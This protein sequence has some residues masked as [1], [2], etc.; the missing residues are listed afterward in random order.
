MYDYHEVM[1]KEVEEYLTPLFNDYCNMDFDEAVDQFIDELWGSY[2]TGNDGDNYFKTREEAFNAVFAAPFNA[3]LLAAALA[4]FD[5]DYK[6][7]LNDPH[8]AYTT[9]RCYL[10]FEIVPNVWREMMGD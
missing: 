8:Y 6:R 4:E 10:L 5:V 3:R 9:I 2:V 7:A 1:E